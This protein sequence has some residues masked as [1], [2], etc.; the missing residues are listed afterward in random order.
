VRAQ[1]VGLGGGR[2]G[3][4]PQPARLL[5]RSGGHRIPQLLC[6]AFA[7]RDLGF[8][9]QDLRVNGVGFRVQGLGSGV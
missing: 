5:R 9:A 8:S 2:G 3:G 6:A 1:H 7:A 4:D